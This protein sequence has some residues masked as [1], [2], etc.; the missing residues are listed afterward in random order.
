MADL[1][2]IIDA[3]GAKQGADQFASAT[4]QVKGAASSM[5]REV[6]K[7]SQA[8]AQAG[9]GTGAL[10]RSL[11]T[12][13]P[14]QRRIAEQFVRLNQ[15]VGQGV[16]SWQQ[17][18]RLAGLVT[19]NYEAASRKIHQLVAQ[20]ARGEQ[21]A[22]GMA[23]ATQHQVNQLRGLALEAQRAAVQEARLVGLRQRLA[24][25]TVGSTTAT[26]GNVVATTRAAAGFERLRAPLQATAFGMAGIPGPAGRAAAALGTL[27]IGGPL[28]VGIVAGLAII[29]ATINKLHG[30]L[31][32]LEDRLDALREKNKDP[33][34]QLGFDRQTRERQIAD[35]D[36]QLADLR[37]N[38]IVGASGAVVEAAQEAAINRLV[39]ER[40]KLYKDVGD[41][42]REQAAIGEEKAKEARARGEQVAQEAARLAAEQRQQAA[43]RRQQIAGLRD[44]ELAALAAVARARRDTAGQA[45]FE[46]Q[47]KLD[48]LDREVDAQERLTALE[49]DR[50]RAAGLLL[51]AVDEQAKSF[52]RALST[53]ERLNAE[54]LKMTAAPLSP[55]QTQRTITSGAPQV[56]TGPR[57][58]LLTVEDARQILAQ[59]RRVREEAKRA[60][61]ELAQVHLE[62]IRIYEQVRLAGIDMARGIEGIPVGV[63][64][65][66]AAFVTLQSRLGQLA[67]AQE[68]AS[69]AA[70]RAALAQQRAAAIV[71]GAAQ[72]AQSV[73]PDGGAGSVLQGGVRGAAAGFSVGGPLGGVVGG[74]VGTVSSL[75]GLGDKAA[76]EARRMAYARAEWDD[77][78]EDFGRIGSRA[79][80]P[81]Q[82][83]LAE[84]EK[85]LRD[86]AEDLL[87]DFDIKSTGPIL[88]F[89]DFVS[90]FEEYLRR[91]SPDAEF[92]RR[93]ERLIRRY[94]DGL[95]ELHAE[96]ER[97]RKRQSEDL[98]VRIL[99]AQGLDLEAEALQVALD[100]QRALEQLMRDGYDPL[101]AAQL[102]YLAALQHEQLAKRAATEAQRKQFEEANTLD[103]LAARRAR[104]YGT[105]PEARE[106]ELIAERNRQLRDAGLAFSAGE[107]SQDV[108][109]QLI[110]VIYGEFDRAM[111]DM[112]E[113]IA[114][115]AA[116]AE[117]A[118]RRLKDDLE[119]RRLNVLG[120]D[121]EAAALR[122]RLEVEDYLARGADAVTIAILTMVQ[123]MERQAVAVEELKRLED[124]LRRVREI[125]QRAYENLRVR[126]LRALGQGAA[127]ED[128]S[129]TLAGQEE[130]RRFREQ[131]V[132]GA[133]IEETERILALERDFA[134]AER[135][136]QQREEFERAVADNFSV[137][138]PFPVSR[139][140]ISLAA[141]TSESTGAQI[142]SAL[143]SQLVYWSQHI[144]EQ[145]LQTSIL[146]SIARLLSRGVPIEEIDRQ[147]A[148]LSA[149]GDLAAGLQPSNR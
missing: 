143:T 67:I 84:F 72:I 80:S 128:L 70:E 83:D 1:T 28:T 54:I 79:L 49:R 131:G 29:I 134:D 133:V 14:E 77:A 146:S 56:V 89:E 5:D 116:E 117:R 82:R 76:E 132:G 94:T 148:L 26:A 109:A 50:L 96:F 37:R 104:L 9:Q 127:A 145:R 137:T 42:R 142:A 92:I 13:S 90:R 10:A 6:R 125:T 86:L 124:D 16:I 43:Q 23:R 39:Q 27:S 69:T 12:L 64:D 65:A 47:A 44:A 101:I 113:T 144:A 93:G 119:L 102:E 55:F 118:Q 45:A 21:A 32:E 88:G 85:E 78:L 95:A 136:R 121:E 48:R 19:T 25:A 11:A 120:M 4:E 81:L 63:L 138:S 98:Q 108:F 74:V 53:A 103:S 97:G 126:E 75:F 24:G 73:V 3:T 110:E 111:R 62:I 68:Q 100:Y 129:R 115:A 58:G 51:L 149:D 87:K 91:A 40:A 8:F 112:A 71:V 59:D 20:Q 106:A 147:L 33:L 66:A 22:L 123:A 2:L 107:I 36:R 17:Q 46:L 30:P 135:R 57:P 105:D 38:P 140:S 34:I 122:D 52:A 7:T 114:Q 31:K 61:R 139:T 18:A 15:L 130:I 60:A 99:Q 141:G 41:I 35:I